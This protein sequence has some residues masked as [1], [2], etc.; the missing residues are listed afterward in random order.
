MVS[1]DKQKMGETVG[2]GVIFGETGKWILPTE[3]S[4]VGKNG[5]G[6]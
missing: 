4:V 2:R 5:S 6:R 1:I 3:V